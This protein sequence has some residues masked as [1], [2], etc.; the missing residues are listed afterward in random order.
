MRRYRD[1]NLRGLNIDRRKGRRVRDGPGVL[2][3]L[4]AILLALVVAAVTVMF[5]QK[6]DRRVNKSFYRR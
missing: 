2:R 5:V 3:V 6:L 1:E 4:V